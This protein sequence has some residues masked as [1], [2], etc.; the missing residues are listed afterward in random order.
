[1]NLSI[2][3]VVVVTYPWVLFDPTAVGSVLMA[4]FDPKGVEDGPKD[5]SLD[6]QV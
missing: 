5:P 1:M 3:V 6:T 2:S 4:G